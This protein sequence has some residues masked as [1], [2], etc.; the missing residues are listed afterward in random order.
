MITPDIANSS[1]YARLIA[2]ERL[3]VSLT[4]MCALWRDCTWSVHP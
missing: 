2:L 3:Y 4:L 1:R